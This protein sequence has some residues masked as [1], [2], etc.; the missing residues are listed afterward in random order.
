MG[1]ETKLVQKL[2]QSLLMTPQL[3][4]AIK[5]LQ[6][7]R[8]EYK[9]AIEKELLENPI[10]EEVK[11][12]E[13]FDPRKQADRPEPEVEA[14][15]SP[16]PQI[17][18][19]Q[20][21][22]G[23]Q[24]AKVD[25]EDYL[26]SFID[27]R[28]SATPKGQNDSEDRPPLEATLTREESLQEHL[29]EQ[30]RHVEL[31]DEERSIAMHIVGNL[32][33]DGYL[34]GSVEELAQ[35]CQLDVESV[36]SVLETVRSFDP[37]GVAASDLGQCL[38]IQL[39]QM[40]LS[41]ALE[42]RIVRDHMDKLE[43]R[44]YDQIAKAENV[45]VETV[46]KAVTTIQGLEPRP[47][48]PFADDT[49]RYVIPDIY[50]YKVGGEYVISLNEDGLPKLRVSPYYLEL[51]RRNDADNLPNRTYLNERLKAA[52]WLIKSIHQRQNT[53]YRVTESIVKFQRE[54][55]DSGIEKL[56]PLVLKDVADDIGMH[57]ST[58]SRVTTNKY[59]HT[60][61][62]IFE[63]KFFFTTGIKTAG[64]DVS[65]STVKDKIKNLI[66]AE[67]PD[68]PISDQKIVEILKQQ[69]IDIARRTVA[70]YRETLGILSSSKRKKLF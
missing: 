55:F 17:E 68:D 32:D 24:E 3:Q 39:D 36:K 35:D 25:W 64:G 18:A 44:K 60:S 38:L 54:F 26:E 52:S 10:L 49:T 4:Q 30:L 59:V 48:R 33:K 67:P 37:P 19:E 27:S 16:E 53:I 63:L 40:G 31:S 43:K 56:K 66:A 46:Y 23:D 61:Q 14:A 29:L 58:V 42:S 45:S 6:L 7:G 69:N 50:V 65:S 15:A 8:L 12:D 2:S 34:C 22:K 28:G 21:A 70:K 62:G 5:L 1:L 20:P 13:D 11:E 57:E 9:E 47:G 51:L 41:E